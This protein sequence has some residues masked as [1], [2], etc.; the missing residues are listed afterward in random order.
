MSM[1][2]FKVGLL[3]M[4]SGDHPGRNLKRA[5]ELIAQA[6]Q[7]GADLVILPENVFY[8]GPRNPVGFSRSDLFLEFSDSGDLLETSE[9]S[10]ELLKA[11]SDANLGVVVGAALEKSKDPE[12]PYNTQI[13]F[14]PGQKPIR[15]QKMHLF[16]FLGASAQ[17]SES[18]DCT[19]GRK[20]MSF[21]FKG[22]RFGMSICFDL[23]FPELYRWLLQEEGC[24]VLLVPSAFTFETGK[25]HWHT[26]LRSRAIE[27]LSYVLAPGQYGSHKN[28]SGAELLCFGHSLAYGPWGELIWEAEASGDAVGIVTLF[29]DH[30]E[31]SR[32]RLGAIQ[33]I[34]P[35]LLGTGS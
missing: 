25:D 7:E 14:L 12:R 22:L 34:R 18:G 8:R 4:S 19:P 11:L 20:P 30:I 15:Y 5:F 3:Q 9:L 10:R 31:K 13:A 27:N 17:Y 35:E 16:E 2:E 1:S 33:S 29:K 26:L 28:S 6:R 23:R 32:Q 21:E 24:H